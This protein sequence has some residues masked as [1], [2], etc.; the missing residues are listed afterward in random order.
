MREVRFELTK[1][2]SH[3]I[4]YHRS[5]METDPLIIFVPSNSKLKIRNL[6]FGKHIKC[7]LPLWPI[8]DGS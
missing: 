1:A 7:Y 2:L 5:Q 3:R 8:P 4:A 6:K